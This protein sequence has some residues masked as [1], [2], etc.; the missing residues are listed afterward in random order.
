MDMG[1]IRAFM[2]CIR[3]RG[4]LLR[5]QL[6]LNIKFFIIFYYFSGGRPCFVY[7]RQIPKEFELDSNTCLLGL[8]NGGFLAYLSLKVKN[9]KFV[10][11]LI[12]H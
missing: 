1:A 11:L 4:T 2:R 6:F 8:C 3:V 10:F 5:Y 12:L 7:F 9:L